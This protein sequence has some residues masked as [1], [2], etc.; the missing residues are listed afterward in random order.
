MASEHSEIESTTCNDASQFLLL[1]QIVLSIIEKVLNQVLVLDPLL[2]QSLETIQHKRLIVEIRDWQQA[3]QIVFD[4]KRL[5][6]FTAARDSDYDCLISADIN[7]LLTL[8]NPAMLTQL[9]RQDKLDLQGDLN[10]AQTYSG[11]FSKLNIDWPEQF[12]KYMPD[13]AAQQL[14]LNLKSIHHNALNA[15]TKI[16]ALVSSLFQDELAVTIHPL[17]LA[18]FKQRN[19]DV[20]NH[21]SALE[22]RINVLIRTLN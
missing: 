17:E 16:N 3:L 9:I 5:H 6:L 7:T 2:S 21:V 11:A 4:G 1:P 22:Q 14:Y 15:S 12:S 13:A 8:K 18:Q 19:R 20:K 10:I